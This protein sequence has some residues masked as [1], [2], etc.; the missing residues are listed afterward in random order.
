MLLDGQLTIGYP[1]KPNYHLPPP[2]LLKRKIII[3]NKKKADIKIEPDII[4]ENEESG[5]DDVM[6]EAPNDSKAEKLSTEQMQL[7]KPIMAGKGT[8][9]KETEASAK[10]SD[11]VNYVQ[12][13][14]FH[15]F[16]QA[17][18]QQKNY[19][20]SSITE[21]KT[22]ALLEEQ[23]VEFYPHGLRL[24][25]N[26]IMPHLFWS[27]GVQMAVLNFQTLDV[28]MQL[29]LALF[30]YNNHC[31]YLLKPDIMRREDI[32]F[33]P[34][35]QS[36]IDSIVPAK[37]YIEVISG[38]LL[39]DKR[40]GTNVRVE[41]CGIPV[42]AKKFRTKTIP[43]NGINPLYDED[44]FVFSRVV[45]P[46]LA[47]LRLAFYEAS[48]QIIGHRALPINATS[49]G[50]KYNPLCN[51]LGQPLGLPSIFVHIKVGDS[52][53]DEHHEITK[54]LL[55]PTNDT[56]VNTPELDKSLIKSVSFSEDW[57]LGQGFVPPEFLL[58]SLREILEAEFVFE[59]RVKKRDKTSS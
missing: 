54:T 32:S 24:S 56:E 28:L 45:F 3:E 4:D 9:G 55:H 11:L 59:K 41:M 31:G 49:P 25:S 5:D 30:D 26:I 17:K 1:L 38:Q 2:S 40:I 44:P 7:R 13:V 48:G 16:E 52:V 50:Y 42:N 47:F 51:E 37:V 20:M 53:R 58:L 39:S 6:E 15:S 33:N 29:N 21:W 27:A 14:H 12:P 34:W 8:V 36:T 23:P 10:I 19:E 35:S 57:P 46:D 18:L 43:L 22:K